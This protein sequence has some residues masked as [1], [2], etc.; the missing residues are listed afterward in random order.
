MSSVS[1][2]SWPA[3]CLALSFSEPAPAALVSEAEVARGLKEALTQG[4]NVAVT[5]LGRDGGFLDD[6]EVRIGLPPSLSSAESVARKLGLGRY[7]DQLITAMNHAAE[8]AIPEAQSLLLD[9]VRSM[10]VEDA[11][12]ILSGGDD[13][14]T[15]YFR[16]ETE[17]ALTARM[18]PI[19][20]RVTSQVRLAESYNQFVRKGARY[21]LVKHGEPDLDL[22]VTRKALDAL[23]AKVAD[24]ERSIRQRPLE[25]SARL[26]RRVFGS[27]TH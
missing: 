4:V 17:A 12:A 5:E 20:E 10:T 24:E 13:A 18:R 3:L 2:L 21:G 23:Y 27:L 15:A 7:P 11:T 22:Y 19:V 14:A 6:E 9:A 25:Q 26:L 16:R 1:R 8:K